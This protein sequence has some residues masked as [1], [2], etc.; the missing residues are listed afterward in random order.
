MLFKK[1]DFSSKE[2]WHVLV[3]RNDGLGDLILTLPL[4]ASLKKQLGS[5]K[6]QVTFLVNKNFEKFCQHINEIDEVLVDDGFL[7]KRHR[8]FFDKNQRKQKQRKLLQTIQKKNFDIVLCVYSE[9][10]TARLVGHSKI[11]IRVGALR[12]SFFYNFNFFFTASR[13]KSN[14]PEWQLNLLYLK[15]LG[16]DPAYHPPTLSRTNQEHINQYLT[17][18]TIVVHPYKRS[19]TAKVWSLQNFSRL[20]KELSKNYQVIVVGDKQDESFLKKQFY[21]IPNIQIICH[22]SLMDLAYLISK[23]IFFVGNSSGPLHVAGLVGVPHIGFFPAEKPVS[24]R[25]WQSLPAANIFFP[26]SLHSNV[27]QVLHWIFFYLEKE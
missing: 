26:F 17:S 19:S 15:V 10:E 4:A 25:R 24:A 13:K 18:N 2:T 9:K 1:I 11:P 3:V 6:V 20:I 14:L 27:E 16:L 5:E 23:S 7:L 21:A 8:S 12:R 22:F